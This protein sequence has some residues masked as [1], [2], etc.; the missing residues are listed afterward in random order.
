MSLIFGNNTP[1]LKK[2]AFPISKY[3]QFSK[4]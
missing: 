2:T 1:H 4:C 3:D